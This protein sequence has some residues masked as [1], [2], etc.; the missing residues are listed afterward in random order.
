MYGS[1][2]AYPRNT[3]GAHRLDPRD[4]S[5]TAN[6]LGTSEGAASV[7]DLSA[8]Y[9]TGGCVLYSIPCARVG[10]TSPRH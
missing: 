9:S 2:V 4:P 1:E 8:A 3:G 7:T 6:G 10:V 5:L